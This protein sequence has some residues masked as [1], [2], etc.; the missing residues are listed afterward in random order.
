MGRR[1]RFGVDQRVEMIEIPGQKIARFNCA[2]FGSWVGGNGPLELLI[3]FIRAYTAVRLAELDALIIVGT[4]RPG[5]HEA[6]YGPHILR[7]SP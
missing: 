7:D 3:K 2:T 1:N 4:M 5:H 6:A